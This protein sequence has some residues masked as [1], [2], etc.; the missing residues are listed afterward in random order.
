M[1]NLGCKGCG[2]YNSWDA[3]VQL[4]LPPFTNPTRVEPLVKETGISPFSKVNE[5]SNYEL[6]LKS[7]P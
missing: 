3:N 4:F 1:K 6:A 7:N 2:A 5:T